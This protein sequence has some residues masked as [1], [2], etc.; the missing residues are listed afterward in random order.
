MFESHLKQNNVCI[1]SGAGT[2][3]SASDSEPSGLW[4]ETHL[5]FFLFLSKK[6]LKQNQDLR[7]V[8]DVDFE[9]LRLNKKIHTNYISGAIAQLIECLAG[10]QEDLGSFPRKGGICFT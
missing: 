3:G 2:C 5:S 6:H 10:E 8:C 9:I 1:W 4:F 7:E